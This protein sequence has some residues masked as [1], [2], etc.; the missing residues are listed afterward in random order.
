MTE[1]R[2]VGMLAFIIIGVLVE[3]THLIRLFRGKDK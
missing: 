2:I 3:W 1:M